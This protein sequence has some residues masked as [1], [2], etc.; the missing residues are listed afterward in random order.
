M[1]LLC[2]PQVDPPHL[3]IET[4]NVTQI[5][6]VSSIFYC[7]SPELFLLTWSEGHL[8]L[9]EGFVTVSQQVFGLPVVDSH[10]PK[11]QMAR[12]SQRHLDLKAMVQTYK[13]YK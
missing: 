4:S 2:F 8:D 5:V 3:N 6:N 1:Q 11:E 10:H 7:G 13:I 9:D 12:C